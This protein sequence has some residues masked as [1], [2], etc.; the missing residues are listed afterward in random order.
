VLYRRYQKF[1]GE[2]WYRGIAPDQCRLCG[3]RTHIY[4]YGPYTRFSPGK[5]RKASW[6]SYAK[7]RV[8]DDRVDLSHA[9]EITSLI[10]TAVLD[11]VHETW[12]WLTPSPVTWTCWIV[13]D[14]V[15][16]MTMLA[17]VVSP[18]CPRLRHVGVCHSY[19][20][21]CFFFCRRKRTTRLRERFSR[22]SQM[23]SFDPLWN[24]R[25]LAL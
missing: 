4:A 25:T 10:A 20:G 3:F 16:S 5:C 18:A 11:S 9:T 15:E 19:P 21:T 8:M 24:Q 23:S 7:L 1:V 17:T 2:H 12:A 14:H 22:G 6:G 13:G